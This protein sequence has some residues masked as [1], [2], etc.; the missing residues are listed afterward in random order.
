[1]CW[2]FEK[3]NANTA[4]VAGNHKIHNNFEYFIVSQ[5]LEKKKP[6]NN[7]SNNWGHTSV[8]LVVDK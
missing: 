4:S 6:F 2:R 7:F 8:V 3:L 1:M 5:R